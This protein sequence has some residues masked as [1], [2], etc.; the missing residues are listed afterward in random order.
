MKILLTGST[1]Q[2]GKAINSIKPTYHELLLPKRNELDLSDKEN[3]QKYV[4]FHKPDLIINSGAFTNVDLAEEQSDLC[5]AINVE[6]PLV[7]AKI[8]KEYGGNL[9]QISSDY[10]FDGNQ[11]IPYKINQERNPLSKY[12]QSKSRCEEIIEEIL[13]PT[14]QLVIL[15]ISWL[16]GPIGKN[17]LL[18]I[19]KLHQNKEQFS[20]VDDQIGSISSTYD[21]A[22][23]CW[24]IIS[25]W[26]LFSKC[27]N[28]INHWRCE[29]VASWYDIA[30]AIGEIA[31][32]YQIIKK[33]AKIFPI[34]S[35]DYPTLAKRPPYSILD[36]SNTKKLL[37][38][39]GIYWREELEQIFLKIINEKNI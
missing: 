24:K 12:G 31:L 20:V 7:F 16:I 1:G 28:Y 27:E 6:A 11:N 9:L 14:H 22:K 10:V 15:R 34:K 32:K 26:Q 17:F 36:F 3:C 29:G 37:G 4:E 5:F 35:E 38:I 19:L 39:E 2:L 30:I 33:T 25:D 13:K 21:V 18:T 23:I 8:L